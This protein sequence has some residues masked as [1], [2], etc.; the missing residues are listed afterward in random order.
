[1][2]RRSFVKGAAWSV[3]VIAAAV[4]TPLAAASG[5]HP[6][7]EPTKPP[8]LVCTPPNHDPDVE[9]VSITGNLMLIKFR[10]GAQN[11]VDVTV[12]IAGQ[13]EVHL[14]LVSPGTPTNGVAHMK[15]YL[16]GQV[17]TVTLPDAYNRRRGDWLQVKTVHNENCVDA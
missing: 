7:P 9:S 13:R 11:S 10:P 4:A 2:E 5:P 14:N 1:M 8:I 12:R 6:S 16:P 17:F 3:P 15:N